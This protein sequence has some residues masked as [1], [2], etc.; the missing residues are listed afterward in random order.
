MDYGV[1]FTTVQTYLG[2]ASM[3][4]VRSG[5][6]V[7]PDAYLGRGGFQEHAEADHAGFK[8]A[9]TP[10]ITGFGLGTSW[11]T[12]REVF[13]Y[14][15]GPYARGADGR[16]SMYGEGTLH[17]QGITHVALSG[18]LHEG[19]PQGPEEHAVITYTNENGVS[20]RTV[21]APDY[22]DRQE[23]AERDAD[24]LDRAADHLEQDY[25]TVEAPGR[26]LRKAAAGM[27]YEQCTLAEHVAAVRAGQDA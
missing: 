13:D 21:V 12:E 15:N 22:V 11:K 18:G 5:L 7:D 8:V 1:R 27:R 25:G 24:V 20:I 2:S 6:T 19:G 26:A 4:E 10:G 3:P 16:R 23:R 14:L 9:A 17:W